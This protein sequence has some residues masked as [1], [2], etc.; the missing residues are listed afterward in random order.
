MKEILPKYVKQVSGEPRRRW[1]EDSYF[2]LLVWQNERG[3]I[4]GFQLCYDKSYNQRSLIW[5]EQMGFLHTKVDDG[6][7]RPGKYKAA[8]ILVDD[9]VFDSLSIAEKFKCKSQ[10]I[11]K[12]VSTFVFNKIKEYQC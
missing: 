7:N 11:D 9:G 12:K 1:F 10:D 4:V 6:E 2:D 3:Q 8:P 5:K